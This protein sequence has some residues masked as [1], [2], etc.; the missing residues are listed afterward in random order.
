MKKHPNEKWESYEQKRLKMNISIDPD[1]GC[2]HPIE[3]SLSFGTEQLAQ[4]FIRTRYTNAFS[5]SFTDFEKQI[6]RD[7][8]SYLSKLYE[9]ERLDKEE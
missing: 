2:Q 5:G 9:G 8:V 1:R 3:K 6:S 7:K 4:S